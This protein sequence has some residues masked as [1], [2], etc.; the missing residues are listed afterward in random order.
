MRLISL[1][2]PGWL[3]VNSTSA[4]GIR[5]NGITS[6][7]EPTNSPWPHV[8]DTRANE[9]VG[10]AGGSGGGTGEQTEVP[11]ESTVECPFSES[12]RP[13]AAVPEKERESAA[14]F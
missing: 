2:V 6:P 13:A 11:F 1:K 8:A 7:S 5:S 4:S 12:D 10:A 9:R 3:E 14:K